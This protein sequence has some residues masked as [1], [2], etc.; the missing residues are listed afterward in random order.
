MLRRL[1][2][3][4]DALARVAR[5]ALDRCHFDEHGDDQRE[6]CQAACYQC[7]MSFGNQHEALLLDRHRVRQTLLDWLPANPS[8]G[9]TDATGK[10]ISRGCAP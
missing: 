1:V 9:L 4:A 6:S 5:E 8:L 7:L 10:R 3:E 2:D